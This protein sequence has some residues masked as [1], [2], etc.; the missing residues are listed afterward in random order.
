MNATI[1]VLKEAEIVIP[2]THLIHQFALCRYLMDLEEN[3]VLS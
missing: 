2:H 3:Y 1:E